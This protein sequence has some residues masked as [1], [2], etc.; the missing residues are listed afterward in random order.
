M[1]SN[2]FLDTMP[3]PGTVSELRMEAST[4]FMCITTVLGST[5]SKLSMLGYRNAQSALTSGSR[6]R[7]MENLTSSAVTGDPSENFASRRWKV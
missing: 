4:A 3:P 5:T 1:V 2:A 6:I 7:S